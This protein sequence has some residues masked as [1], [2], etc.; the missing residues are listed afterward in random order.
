M[1]HSTR[2]LDVV[3]ALVWR[4]NELLVTQ[5]PEG[6]HL[7][8]SWEFP[9]GKIELGETAEAALARELR[10][11]LDVAVRIDALRREIVHAYPEK[12]VRLLFFDCAWVGGEVRNVAVADHRWISRHELS[13]LVFPPADRE[14]LAELSADFGPRAESRAL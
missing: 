10:E 1:T 4:G 3:A 14:L 2:A 11:E 7:A 13:T 5:R 8:G 9:G 6:S 12:T